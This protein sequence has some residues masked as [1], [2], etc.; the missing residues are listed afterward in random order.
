MTKR[1]AKG[2]LVLVSVVWMAAVGWYLLQQRTDPALEA[3]RQQQFE[4]KM[5]DCRGQFSERYD[6]TSALLRQ[7]SR[8]TA[9]WWAIRL[10]LLFGPPLA[11]GVVYS[12]FINWYDRRRE[13]ARNQARLERREQGI[14]PYFAGTGAETGT[15][16]VIGTWIGTKTGAE[17]QKEEEP[18]LRE[19]DL[20]RRRADERRRA[21]KHQ[22]QPPEAAP[23]DQPL[24]PT[25][26]DPPSR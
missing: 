8:E 18:P 24:D 13:A 23:D 26:E 22:Y 16:T 21:A 14:Q 25:D 19:I 3:L 9:A 6:C 11:A 17:E 2:L 20:I 12:V 5:K 15:E 10:A 1:L 7:R 4:Q